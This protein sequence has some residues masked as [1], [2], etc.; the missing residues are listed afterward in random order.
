MIPKNALE[1]MH[2]EIWLSQNARPYIMMRKELAELYVYFRLIDEAVKEY[3]D[4]LDMDAFDN[5]NIRGNLASLLLN[6]KRYEDFERLIE[7]YW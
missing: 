5:L 6:E 4:I 7:N 1:G 2:G 3:F